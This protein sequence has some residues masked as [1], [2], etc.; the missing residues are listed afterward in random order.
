MQ[1]ISG[2]G[3]NSTGLVIDPLVGGAAA[4][5][6][7]VLPFVYGAPAWAVARGRFP[8]ARRRRRGR[9]RSRPAPSAAAWA[10]FLKLVVARYGPGGGFWVANP[11]LP[12]QADPDLADLERAELQVLRRPPNPADYGK[13]VNLSYSGDQERRPGGEADPGRHVRAARRGAS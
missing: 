2:S 5:G 11:G 1:P 3:A 13:L 8:A 9:C 6:I 7:N 10:D 4:A 12:A